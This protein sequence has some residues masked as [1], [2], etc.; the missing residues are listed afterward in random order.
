M[1]KSLRVGI[2][3]VSADSGRAKESHVPRKSYEPCQ[4]VGW[5][6]GWEFLGKLP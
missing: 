3:G 1:T 6:V 5:V 2:I 4:T